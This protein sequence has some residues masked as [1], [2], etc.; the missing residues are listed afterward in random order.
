ML[1]SL[2][3][4]TVAETWKQNQWCYYKVKACKH[5]I[6]TYWRAG[7]LLDDYCLLYF[8][9]CYGNKGIITAHTYISDIPGMIY[10]ALPNCV[11][12]NVQK[13]GVTSFCIKGDAS[14]S[15]SII[16]HCL[17]SRNTQCLE[18][19]DTEEHAS[20]NMSNPGIFQE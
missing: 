3:T 13:R 20:R 6:V 2:F 7:N 18:G 19:K 8:K 9:L 15:S 14:I 5:N 16:L 10:V 11:L 4:K 12:G 17:Q 1:S